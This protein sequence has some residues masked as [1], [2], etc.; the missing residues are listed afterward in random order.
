MTVYVDTVQKPYR[1]MLMCHMVADTL[2]ELHAMADKIGVRRQWFQS[3]ASTSHYDICKS[4]KRLAL[5]YGAVE[6]DRRKFVEVI[7]RL[8]RKRNGNRT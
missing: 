6:L 4:K 2:D 3:H 7:R 8:R 5:K 1:R